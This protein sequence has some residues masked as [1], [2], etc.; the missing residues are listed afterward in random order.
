VGPVP[1][2]SAQDA[3]PEDV[4]TSPSGEETPE[5]QPAPLLTLR[6]GLTDVV[7][8]P[9]GLAAA[10]AAVA[11]GTGPVALD[12]E[13]A[14]GYRYSARAYLIQLRREG[15]GTWLIDPIAFTDLRA[16]DAA[17]GDAE[18]ILHA[19]TQDLACLREV[20]LVPRALF[21]TEHA[22]RLLGY[23]RVGLATLVETVMGRRMRKEH[24]AVDWSKRPLPRPWLEY[25]ALDVEVL[26]EL[27]EVLG[28]ELEEQGKAEWA[29]EEF[30]YLTGFAPVPRAEPWRRTSGIH[31]MRGRRPLAAVRELWTE[32]DT[33]AAEQDIT[34]GRLL[35]DSALV[36]AA[37]A[38]PSTRGAL[39]ATEGFQGRGAK[40]YADRWLAALSRARELPDADLPLLNQR[41]DGPP[42]QRA[43][44]ERDPVAAARLN[45]AKEAMAAL[46]ER[47][48]VPTENLLTPDLMR[49][50]L[51]TPPPGTGEQL[52]A[53]VAAALAE[54]GARAWQ[55][56]LTAPLLADAIEGASAS[57]EV[58]E[59]AADESAV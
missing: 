39:L 59:R 5:Q 32:R 27:R 16:L 15:S 14:S 19:A 24:S 34:P 37:R 7:D 47:V 54:M 4:G 25:A 49:R 23:P 18:W 58:Q 3:L 31:R 51:W 40:R 36:A 11:A 38:M 2:G 53:A 9:E 22:A 46:S 57:A 52:R 17:I 55:V 20:G 56:S 42:Q 45:A 6:D 21:D 13:R 50:V 28:R 33:I 10:V 43:W 29:A 41:T 30:A 48:S 44:A 12:A 26:I 1:E 8:S 35:P